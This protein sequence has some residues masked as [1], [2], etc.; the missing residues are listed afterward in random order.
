MINKEPLGRLI[1]DFPAIFA[2]N[3]VSDIVVQDGDSI[4]IPRVSNTISVIGEVRREGV[5][6]YQDSL[7]LDDC[8]E[9]SAG[10]TVRADEDAIYVIKADGS[11]NT[12]QNNLF[13][14]SGPSN[15]LSPGDTIVIPVNPQYRDTISYWSTVT[16]IIYQTGIAAATAI[17]LF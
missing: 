7:T 11:V 14:F 12:L 1:I 9:L 6:R 8:L 10:M 2:G 5:H 15:S 17:A 4:E 13:S 3:T 16:G